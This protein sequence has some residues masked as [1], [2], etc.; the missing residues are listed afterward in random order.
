LTNKLDT[1][2]TY[3][4]LTNNRVFELPGNSLSGVGH[5]D[6]TYMSLPGI[7]D[8]GDRVIWYQRQQAQLRSLTGRDCADDHGA[9][10][11]RLRHR[12]ASRGTETLQSASEK[13]NPLHHEGHDDHEKQ[14]AFVPFVSSCFVFRYRSP[15]TDF[16]GYP[17]SSTCHSPG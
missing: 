16:D 2:T 8:T 9:T 5:V 7:G 3:G 1:L 17:A 12:R 10:R 14:E 13:E 6:V 4:F 15:G 11:L